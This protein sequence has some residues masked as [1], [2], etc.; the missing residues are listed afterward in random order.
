[1]ARDELRVNSARYLL[2]VAEPALLQQQRQEVR[3][4]EQVAQLVEELRVVA[5]ERRVR[6]LVR[7]LD[8]VRDDR[9]RRLLAIPGA[10]AAKP[11]GQLL[12]I[13]ERA[14]E[15]SVPSRRC[16]YDPSSSVVVP[17]AEAGGLNPTW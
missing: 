4:E 3:L 17:V 2:E 6:D 11:F 15:L 14:G 9:L 10:V 13:E 8:G 16:R 5:A 12:E 7:L 1:M